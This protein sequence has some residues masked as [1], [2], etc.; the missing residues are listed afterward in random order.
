MRR[1]SARIRRNRIPTIAALAAFIVF[2]LLVAAAGC[3]SVPTGVAPLAGRYELRSV[4]GRSLPDDRLGGAVD[5][6]LVLTSDGRATRT[7]RY[8]TS[9]IPGPITRRASGSFSRRG[10]E[11][12]LVLVRE[13]IAL[14]EATWE[15]RGEARPPAI[16]LRYRG[17][18]NVDVEEVYVRTP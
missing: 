8:A 3:S 5:G 16:T 9:G 14:P 17:P 7:V 13:G 18:R 2:V 11:I 4:D 12:T 6:Q 1:A 10:E 15:V